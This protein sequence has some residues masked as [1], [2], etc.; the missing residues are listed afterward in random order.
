MTSCVKIISRRG[1]LRKYQTCYC[2]FIQST[3]SE[4]S[5]NKTVGDSRTNEVPAL[6]EL[7]LLRD[8]QSC[9]LE[10]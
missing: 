8:S 2:S 10:G 5:G 6:R 1:A 3:F 7:S 4:V 9:E